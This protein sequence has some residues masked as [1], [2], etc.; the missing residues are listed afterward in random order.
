MIFL[1]SNDLLQS[2]CES[3]DERKERYSRRFI[4]Y[5]G[6]IFKGLAH[7]NANS[8][9]QVTDP[10]HLY[11][12]RGSSPPP[13]VPVGQPHPTYLWYVGWGSLTAEI[14]TVPGYKM[15]SWTPE[16]LVEY[17]DGCPRPG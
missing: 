16:L 1:R 12:S 7:R 2:P 4:A 11:T 9:L 8:R 15:H 13:N 17:V 10:A 5:I 6:I 3:Q 14:E